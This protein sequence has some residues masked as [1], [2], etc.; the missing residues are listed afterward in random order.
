MMLDR[1]SFVKEKDLKFVIRLAD[2][3]VNLSVY[4][5]YLKVQYVP[6]VG[7]Q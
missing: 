2:V 4:M 7:L 5:H 6:A 1:H 3:F